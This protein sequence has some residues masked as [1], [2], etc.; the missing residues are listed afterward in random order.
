MDAETEDGL[1][2]DDASDAQSDDDQRA[3]AEPSDPSAPTLRTDSDQD[4]QAK[5]QP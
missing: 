2:D 5:R 1:L 4:Q 3:E